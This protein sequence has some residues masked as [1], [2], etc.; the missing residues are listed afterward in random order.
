[1]P[2]LSSRISA[3]SSI[4]G[5]PRGKCY[6]SQTVTGRSEGPGRAGW[7]GYTN[8]SG[9]CRFPSI[10]ICFRCEKVTK[11][12]GQGKVYTRPSRVVL[13]PSMKTF[14]CWQLQPCV[15]WEGYRG[16]TRFTQDRWWWRVP[17]SSGLS[18]ELPDSEGIMRSRDESWQFVLPSRLLLAPSLG[19]FSSSWKGNLRRS[20]GGGQVSERTEARCGVSVF[21]PSLC[22][23]PSRRKKLN[24]TVLVKAVLVSD[25]QSPGSVSMLVVPR[26]GSP[27]ALSVGPHS[28]HAISFL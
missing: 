24:I 13:S 6:L 18:R 9:I 11:S 10:F 27:Q 1:M 19:V 14:M 16:K 22:S 3:Q 5:W 7:D 20:A 28:Y 15:S 26:E 12:K 23:L 17:G 8:S 2:A 4:S 25:N 21:E